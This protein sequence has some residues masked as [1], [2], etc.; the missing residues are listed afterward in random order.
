MFTNNENIDENNTQDVSLRDIFTTYMRAV[1]Q[2][3]QI[4]FE[5]SE[6]SQKC[7]VCSDVISHIF[8]VMMKRNIPLSEIQSTCEKAAILYTESLKLLK[9]CLPEIHLKQ[10]TDIKRLVYLK[11][12]GIYTIVDDD[13]QPVHDSFVYKTIHT[14]TPILQNLNQITIE[15]EGTEIFIP[16][17]YLFMYSLHDIFK[18]YETDGESI[19][20]RFIHD[21]NKTIQ[22]CSVSI[23]TCS[24]TLLSTTLIK[25]SIQAQLFLYIYSKTFNHEIALICFESLDFETLKTDTF[26]HIRTIQDVKNMPMYMNAIKQ[27][28]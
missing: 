1:T 2:A 19:V 6:S 7:V 9:Y 24:T 21:I 27:L 26:A 22:H 11:T 3:M 20:Y 8:I 10:I 18:I 5:F 28:A 25:L 23:K 14:I 4:N 17:L 16:H 13:I 15:F 12:I